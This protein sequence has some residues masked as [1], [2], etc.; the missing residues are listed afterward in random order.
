MS[1]PLDFGLLEGAGAERFL[2]ERW[3]RLVALNPR[4]TAFQTAAWYRGWV[5]SAARAEGAE[6][7]LLCVGP[8]GAPRAALALQRTSGGG[9]PS[10][11]S[12]SWPWSDYHEAVGSALDPEA[13]AGLAHAL[14]A[15]PG[16]AGCPLVLDEAI[17]GG[18]LDAAASAAGASAEASSPTEAIDLDDGP[19]VERVLGHREHQVKQ[20]RLERAGEVRCVHHD[21]PEEIGR[22]LEDFIALHREQWKG[23]TEAVAPFDGGA[24]DQ[25]FHAFG[26]RLAERGGVLLTELSL[27]GRPIAMYFGMR[28]GAWYGG[29]RTAFAADL[30]RLSPGHLMLRRMISDFRRAGLRWLD[31]MRGSYAYK[32]GYTNRVSRNR[33]FVLGKE[34]GGR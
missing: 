16:L 15:L 13:V 6:P 9:E 7:V 23:R 30:Y 4:A 8:P 33:R 24:V 21:S 18:L 12:L 2:E 5:E 14:A 26:R 1:R 22:H 20:R 17:P 28:H 3:D 25:A 27:S 32:R 10:L 19:H 34:P 11:R 31:L 29:Y